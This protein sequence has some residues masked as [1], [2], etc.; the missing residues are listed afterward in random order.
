MPQG[1][2]AHRVAERVRVELS[3]LL[4]RS[5]RDPGIASVA[6]TRVSMSVDLQLARVFYTLAGDGDRREAARSLRRARSY[7]RREIGRRI[8]LRYVPELRFA[9][10]DSTEKQDRIARLFD[11]IANKRADTKSE[12]GENLG[13][14]NSGDTHG[15]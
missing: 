8:Q 4:T 6:I 14:A 7:L 9:Y 10:D 1:I 2:R 13:D 3:T 12:Q 15:A 5:V 11:E